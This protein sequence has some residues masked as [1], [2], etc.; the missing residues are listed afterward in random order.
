ML[1][2]LKFL[3]NLPISL[4]LGKGKGWLDERL[5]NNVSEKSMK[6]SSSR[7]KE[8]EPEL[9][10]QLLRGGNQS[11]WSSS[12]LTLCC[13]YNQILIEIVRLSNFIPTLLFYQVIEIFGCAPHQLMVFEKDAP[14]FVL[15]GDGG[16]T[17]FP[18]FAFQHHSLFEQKSE[19][20]FI[21]ICFWKLKKSPQAC[22]VGPLPKV[23]QTGTRQY[24]S[25]R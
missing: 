16:Q 4:G 23:K 24:S 19:H 7:A 10:L 1:L 15:G 18:V 17:P 13:N 12:P 8:P 5:V 6:K 21:P 3:Y 22:C 11:S 20:S 25:F 9:K 14:F 2:K